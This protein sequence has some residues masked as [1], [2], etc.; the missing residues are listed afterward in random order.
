MHQQTVLITGGTSGIGLEAVRR[1]HALGYKVITCARTLAT[2]HTVLSNHPQLSDVDFQLTDLGSNSQIKGL[3]LHIVSTYGSLKIA[4]NNA[5]PKIA[6]SGIFAEDAEENLFSTLLSD[7][8]SP[9]LCLRNELQLMEPGGAIVNISSVNGIRPAP[10]NS[11]Y[12]AAKHG[13][14]GLTRSVALEAIEKGIRVNSVAP[15][16][17]WTS[18]WEARKANGN[19]SIKQDVEKLIPVRRFALPSEIVDAIEW[20]CSDKA[21]Y[22]VGHTLV[23]DGGLSLK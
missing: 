14:E 2:W 23:V 1:F 16:V 11:M 3:F 10:N 17:T 15:G 5:S 7:L 21:S 8:W 13:L 22:V 6:S 19:P 9:A 20:L 4:I 18:R 12:A